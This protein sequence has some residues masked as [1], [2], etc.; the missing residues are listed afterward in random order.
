M[1]DAGTFGLEEAARYVHPAWG[2]AG[3]GPTIVVRDERGVDVYCER[4]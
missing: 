4:L 3:Y 1:P 2:Y